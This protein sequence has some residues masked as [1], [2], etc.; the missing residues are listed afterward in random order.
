MSSAHECYVMIMLMSFCQCATAAPL[1]NLEKFTFHS[2]TYAI[3]NGKKD[4]D[5]SA[6][7][8]LLS[9]PTNMFACRMQ[10]DHNAFPDG[11]GVGGESHLSSLFFNT[12]TFI[13][14]LNT[15]IQ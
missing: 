15:E 10:M 6:S 2:Q 5:G 1:S 9:C 12:L 7:P 8:C 11:R 4:C 3:C 14:G 13:Q